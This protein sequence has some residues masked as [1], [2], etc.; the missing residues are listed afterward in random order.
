MDFG[1]SELSSQTGDH[2][3]VFFYKNF[4]QSIIE[5]KIWFDRLSLNLK[6]HYGTIRNRGH[7]ITNRKLDFKGANMAQWGFLGNCENIMKNQWLIEKIVK[8]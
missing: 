6:F 4:R 8:L 3:Y 1:K 2:N 7:K 5:R